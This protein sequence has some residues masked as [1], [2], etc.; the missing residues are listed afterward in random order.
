VIEDNADNR[1]ALRTF[2]RLDGH[3][4]E[5]AG[6]G[7]SGVEMARAVRPEVAL[8]DIGLPGLDG[9]EVGSRIRDDLGTS[10]MLCAI[11]GYGRP[12]DVRR[13]TDAGFDTHL[14]KPVS[15]DALRDILATRAGR[16][17]D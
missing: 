17:P 10:V 14:V 7:V 6:D 12:E 5:V 2:L 9:Y 1:D 3:R 11:T 15:P 4:V 13:A 16:P 8:I